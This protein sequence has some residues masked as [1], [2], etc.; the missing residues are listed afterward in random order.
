MPDA[1]E[2]PRPNLEPENTAKNPTARDEK[3]RFIKGMPS[4]NPG[5]R[6]R[7]AHLVAM[8]REMVESDPERAK[9]LINRWLRMAE[10]RHRGIKAGAQLQ[11]LTEIM[12]RLYGRPAQTVNVAPIMDEATINRLCDLAALLGVAPNQ[13]GASARKSEGNAG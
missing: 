12:D 5:G 4:P 11:A 2:K 7:D 3:G 13:L 6:P 1:P 9:G 10:G 8:L